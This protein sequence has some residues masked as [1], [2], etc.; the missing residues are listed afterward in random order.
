MDMLDHHIVVTKLGLVDGF[1]FLFRICLLQENLYRHEGAI[2]ADNLTGT[3]FIGELQAVLIEEQGNL[4]TDLCADSLGHIVLG[5]AVTFP[6]NRLCALLIGKGIDMNLVRYHEGRVKA[7]S[8]MTDDL[9]VIG[10]VLVFLQEISR[11]GKGDLV[12]VFLDLVCR[13]AQ[14]GIDE[15]QCFVLRIY[16]HADAV[17]MSLR[18]GVF[19]NQ[20][21]LFELRDSVAAV[22]NQLT[23][24]DIVVGIE[25]LF[26]N[27]ENIFTV[28][29]KASMCI[30]HCNSL[31]L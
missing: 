11:A 24:K 26:D 21:K 2:L 30:C 14:S 8:E 5:A 9:I 17:F 23:E 19:A 16:H 7:Q 4:G 12:D 3:V 27:R 25:P 20:G 18:I 1:V 10:L 6:V 28:N 15:F 13:H 22:G 31:L 29:G